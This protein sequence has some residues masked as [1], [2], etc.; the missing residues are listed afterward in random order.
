LADQMIPAG[1]RRVYRTGVR[2]RLRILRAAERVIAKRGIEAA[3]LR[4]ITAAAGVDLALVNYHF[5]SKERLCIEVLLRR[6]GPIN[7]MRLQQLSEARTKAAPRAIKV[8]AIVDAFLDPLFARLIS[9]SS[10]WRDWGKVVTRIYWSP[11]V[12]KH[13]RESIDEVSL[14]FIEELRRSLPNVRP[15][16][17]F[18]RYVFMVSVVL[19][20]LHGSARVH[21]LSGGVEDIRDLRVAKIEA[22][23]FILAGLKATST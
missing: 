3:S 9:K 20:V 19:E 15:G 4:E 17:L 14:V 22:R 23:D 13:Q 18:F 6:N 16:S 1:D 2:T 11:L 7:K 10:G 8:E 21:N 12:L 5:G